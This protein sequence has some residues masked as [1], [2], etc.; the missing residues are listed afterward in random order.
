MKI[1]TYFGPWVYLTGSLVIVLVAFLSSV[2]PPVRLSLCLSQNIHSHTHTQRE[3][4]LFWD[5]H[6]AFH[7]PC[8]DSVYRVTNWRNKQTNNLSWDTTC[9]DIV[10]SLNTPL[11][12]SVYRVTNRR[13]KLSWDTTLQDIV[14]SL[15]T[16]RNDSVYRVTKRRKKLSWD[17]T[18]N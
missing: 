4:H 12:D 3:G 8:N 14:Y 17:T 1:L 15:Y 2:S 16:P 11:N 18:L 7:T 5:W 10:Y 6:S 9:N 13:K